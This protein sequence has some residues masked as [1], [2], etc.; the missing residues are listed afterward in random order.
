M[1]CL[2]EHSCGILQ[3]HRTVLLPFADATCMERDLVGR[4]AAEDRSAVEACPLCNQQMCYSGQQS[5]QEEAHSWQVVL[6]D[7]LDSRQG[8]PF[9]AG[10]ETQNPAEVLLVEWLGTFDQRRLQELLD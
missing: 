2:Q 7:G 4:P 10:V 6:L 3:Q 8:V 9:L 5:K 1:V